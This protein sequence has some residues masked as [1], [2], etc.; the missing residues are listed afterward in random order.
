M[1]LPSTIRLERRMPRTAA[2][3]FSDVPANLIVPE[4]VVRLHEI[5][6]DLTEHW[7]RLVVDSGAATRP[8]LADLAF[9]R[10]ELPP[11]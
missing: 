8:P 1:T 3:T 11:M 5:V 10:E 4:T 9:V 6:V 2:I 7:L